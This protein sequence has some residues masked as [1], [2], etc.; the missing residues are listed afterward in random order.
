MPTSAALHGRLAALL[1]WDQMVS[2]CSLTKLKAL[3]CRFAQSALGLHSSFSQAWGKDLTQL[4]PQGCCLICHPYMQ[5]LPGPTF[6]LWCFWNGVRQPCC[7]C[8]PILAQPCDSKHVCRITGDGNCLIRA[9]AVGIVVMAAGL[10]PED[11]LAFQGRL[12]HLQGAM[13]ANQALLPHQTLPGCGAQ[14][15]LGLQYFQVQKL[16]FI[17]SVQSPQEPHQSWPCGAF[18]GLPRATCRHRCLLCRKERK[19][20][21]VRQS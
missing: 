20:C 10:R 1:L 16:A 14:T 2:H 19:A 13:R 5:L 9:L 4:Q 6:C 17:S 3:P 7:Y 18:P 12:R 21:V 8:S 15:K 11:R